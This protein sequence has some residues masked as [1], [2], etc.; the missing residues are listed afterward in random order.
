MSGPN[1]VLDK[2]YA[3]DPALSYTT[4]GDDLEHPEAYPAI[5][6]VVKITGSGSAG[7]LP[8][9]CNSTA[10]GEK[11]LGVVQ[12]DTPTPTD[13]RSGARDYA[14]LG[15]VVNVRI[16]GITRVVATGVIAVG[17]RVISNGDGTV[18]IAATAT[19]NQ[20]IVGIALGASAATGDQIDLLLTP[21]Q[22]A[23]NP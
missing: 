11:V 20:N 16:L 18:V 22:Q 9:C 17:S 21:G 4:D 13:P 7:Q 15:R 10:S 14:Y 2:G 8:Y 3:L 12:E 5:F 23:N 19:A 1:Q 6:T